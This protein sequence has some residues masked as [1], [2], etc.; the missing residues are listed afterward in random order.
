M[1]LLP[2]PPL[3]DSLEPSASCE[4]PVMLLLLA[5][6]WCQLNAWGQ[7]TPFILLELAEFQDTRCHASTNSVRIWMPIVDETSPGA[8]SQCN[9]RCYPKGA[10]VLPKGGRSEEQTKERW[11]WWCREDTLRGH[12]LVAACGVAEGRSRELQGEKTHVSVL[13]PGKLSKADS[14]S[15]T[16]TSGAGIWCSS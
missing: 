1:F 9:Q 15:L 6:M 16:T 4:T 8:C 7:Q 12:C 5:F 3:S 10:W 14:W 2:T 11:E 13:P